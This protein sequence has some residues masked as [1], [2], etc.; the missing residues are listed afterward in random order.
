MKFDFPRES[1]KF[2]R[3]GG[4]FFSYAQEHL[5]ERTGANFS[6]RSRKYNRSYLQHLQFTPPK[7]DMVF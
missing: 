4:H 7:M 3:E 2:P 1:E 6:V 5:R